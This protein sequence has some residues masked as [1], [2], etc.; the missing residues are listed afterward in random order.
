MPVLFVGAQ[1]PVL[2]VGAQL[3]APFVGTQLRVLLAGAQLPAPLVGA[4]LLVLLAGAQL[5]VLF[6]DTQ[7]P[8]P[9]KDLNSCHETIGQVRVWDR[10]SS[11]QAAPGL[12]SATAPAVTASVTRRTAK[13]AINFLFMGSPPKHIALIF[14]GLTK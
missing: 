11:T 1:L 3:P 9:P 10:P 7:L 6:V 14:Q 5:L 13:M 4:Q 12:H 2:F 8:A